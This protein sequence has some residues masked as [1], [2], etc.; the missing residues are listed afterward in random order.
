MPAE[1]A[2]RRLT[3]TFVNDRVRYCRD[4]QL[5][6]L[7]IHNHG[8]GTAVEFSSIDL[9]SHERGYPALLDIARGQPVGALVIAREAVAGDIWTRDGRHPIGETVILDRN[10]RRLYPRP[11]AAP[12]AH[13]GQLTI[14]KFVST[15]M[16]A[17]HF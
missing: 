9:R 6:Y 13:S 15:A 8:G 14:A 1:H 2:H 12:P 3:A 16:P 4:E 5:A 7:A 17:K 11:S 10:I